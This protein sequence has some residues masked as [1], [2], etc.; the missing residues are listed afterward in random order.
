MGGLLPEQALP[1]LAS[2]TDL[3]LYGM[4]LQERVTHLPPNYLSTPHPPILLP[5]AS[6]QDFMVEPYIHS[7]RSVLPAVLPT[8]HSV[9]TSSAAKMQ[10]GLCVSARRDMQTAYLD[11]QS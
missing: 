8:T 2:S 9:S 7:A 4:A 3:Y 10:N 6:T 11:T 5:P 1:C